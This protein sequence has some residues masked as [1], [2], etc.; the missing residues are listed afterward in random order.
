MS[1]LTGQQIDQYI[2]GPRIG[3]GGMGTVYQAFPTE[4][5]K[6]VAMKVI[7]TDYAEASDFQGR[8]TRE[9]SLMESLDHPNVVPILDHGTTEAGQLYFVMKLISGPTLNKLLKRRQFSPRDTWKVLQ[10]LCLGLHYIH[11][12]G[13]IHRDVKPANVFM[14]RQG[15]EDYQIYL[16]DFGLSKRPGVDRTLTVKNTALGTSDYMSPEA[17][18]G[19][20][21][22]HLTDI[23]SLATTAYEMLL[24]ALP[25]DPQY[26]NLHPVARAVKPLRMPRELNPNFPPMLELVLMRGLEKQKQ[27]RY[28]SVSDFANAYYNALKE[29]DKPTMKQYYS[30]AKE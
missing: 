29:M 19:E 23:Y 7:H 30:S 22:D 24:G 3:G 9:I 28:Q 1:D 6:P 10:P 21:L 8:F 11:E 13:V 5:A 18:M 26:A 16:G 25:S 20:V 17:A 12:H 15:D 27:D 14:E 2:I 4:Q